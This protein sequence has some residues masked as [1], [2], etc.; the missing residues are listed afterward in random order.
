MPYCVCRSVV[1][2]CA[3]VILCICVVALYDRYFS[4]S[5]LC[6]KVKLDRSVKLL[7]EVAS[8]CLY[9]MIFN[10]QWPLSYTTNCLSMHI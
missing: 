4:A 1:P 7:E 3:D 9:R 6:K 5:K 2:L 8:S 10:T